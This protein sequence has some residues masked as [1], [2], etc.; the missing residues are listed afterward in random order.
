MP[1][2][3]AI[4]ELKIEEIFHVISINVIRLEHSLMTRK[5]FGFETV[6][7]RIN[8]ACILKQSQASGR[9]QEFRDQVDLST[10]SIR[11]E[12]LQYGQIFNNIIMQAVLLDSL[13]F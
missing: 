12:R 5:I 10:A 6:T 2:I 8:N 4:T 3:R 13:F 7:L 9:M 1:I 11:S